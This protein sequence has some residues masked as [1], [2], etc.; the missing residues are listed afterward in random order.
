MKT[1]KFIIKRLTRNFGV[2]E[3]L[4]LVDEDCAHL[5]RSTVWAIVHAGNGK[6]EYVARY[7]NGEH[8]FLHHVILGAKSGERVCHI[9]GNGLD[10]RRANLLRASERVMEVEA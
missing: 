2:K 4:V 10:N 3:H 7:I 9:N 5:L 1:K 8:V 6:S